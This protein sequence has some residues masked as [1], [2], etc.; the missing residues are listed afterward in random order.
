MFGGLDLALV[1]RSGRVNV[2][3]AYLRAEAHEGTAPDT[4][5]AVEL[6]HALAFAL[7]PA[8]QVVTVRQ[9]Q[10]R[11]PQ[12]LRVQTKLRARRIAQATVDA[13]GKLPI[14]RQLFRRLCV[15]LRLAGI[16][17]LHRVLFDQ[18]GL[19]RRQV[20]QEQ[21]HVH[22][23]V[24]LH[25]EVRQRFDTNLVRVVAQEGFTAQPGN[26][27][28]HDAAGATNR[29]SARPAVAQ[30]AV[31]LLLDMVQRVEK[32][33]ALLHCNVVGLPVGFRCAVGQVTLDADVLVHALPPLAASP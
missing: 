16:E 11:R 28:D 1:D 24:P 10:R 18:V 26:A 15:G 5:V 9:G 3:G 22:D 4:I 25:G 21:R 23:Q 2:L 13:I 32:R 6:R 31:L 30:R 17:G 33:G 29:H 20:L 19:H 27:V 14:A 12:K 8:V 7:V